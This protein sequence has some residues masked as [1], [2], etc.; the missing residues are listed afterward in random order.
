MAHNYLDY[1]S[2]LCESVKS[3]ALPPISRRGHGFSCVPG[4]ACI[5]TFPLQAF[6]FKIINL[7]KNSMERNIEIAASSDIAA[8]H[9]GR[10]ASAT[11][12]ADIMSSKLVTLSAHH[13]FGQAVQLMTDSFSPFSS[14][15]C[16]WAP[17]RC[18]LRSRRFACARAHPQLAG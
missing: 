4:S 9:S 13:T 10:S 2:F 17:R 14:D 6:D 5:A 11:R 3:S 7:L 8:G 1:F 12:V 15:S 18:L 16:G